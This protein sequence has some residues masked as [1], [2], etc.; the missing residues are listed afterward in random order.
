MKIEVLDSRAAVAQRGAALL[1]QLLRQKPDAL[2][3]LATGATQ[4]PLFAAL[5]E[6][7]QSGAVSFAKARFCHPDEYLG[8]AQD[9]PGSMVATLRREFLDAISLLPERFITIKGAAADWRTEALRY[10][11]RLAAEGGID[12]QFLGLGSNGHVAYNEPG[13]A[14]DGRMHLQRLSP[15]TL[16][17]NRKSLKPGEAELPHD[18]LTLGLGSLLDSRLAVLMATGA[19]KAQQVRRMVKEGPDPHC[20][21]SVLQR[22]GNCV[23]LLDAEAAADL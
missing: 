8:L 5:I 19:A 22:H 12:L 16:A 15:E 1:M 21:A 10:E 2:I 14:L 4:Q 7:Q 6:A 9:H 20:P 17:A 11:A 18:A 13:A 3:G 23:V